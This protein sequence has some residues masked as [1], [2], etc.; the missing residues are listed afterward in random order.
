M[1]KNQIL[2]EVT[3]T[4]R[5]LF[6]KFEDYEQLR[7]FVDRELF[8]LEDRIAELLAHGDLIAAAKAHNRC[9]DL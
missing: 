8:D 4:R 5:T 3:A 2:D 9:Y 6:N 1:N 7:S